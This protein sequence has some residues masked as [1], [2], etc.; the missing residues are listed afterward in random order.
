MDRGTVKLVASNGGI[1][2][3][4]PVTVRDGGANL[5]CSTC[6]VRSSVEKVAK[7][8]PCCNFLPLHHLHTELFAP[9][10]ISVKLLC[11]SDDDVLDYGAQVAICGNQSDECLCQVAGEVVFEGEWKIEAE[12]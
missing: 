2:P 7:A 6:A 5:A 1:R 10:D 11:S 9:S 3:R 12:I 8:A 4:V